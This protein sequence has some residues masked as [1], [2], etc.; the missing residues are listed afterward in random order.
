MGLHTHCLFDLHP[1]IQRFMT[2]EEAI[3]FI[4]RAAKAREVDLHEWVGVGLAGMGHTKQM[5]R[6]GK[7]D[8]LQKQP[9]NY[10]P[11]SLIIC[12]QLQEY[13]REALEVLAGMK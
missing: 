11:Q 12:G 4:Q 5:I 10:F 3:Q 9:W 7:L 13:E 2:V 1:D 6:A 8:Y